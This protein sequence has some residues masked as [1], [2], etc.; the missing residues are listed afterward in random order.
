MRFLEHYQSKPSERWI[1]CHWKTLETNRQSLQAIKSWSCGHYALK[2]LVKKI[3]GRTFFAFLDMFSPHHYDNN[4]HGVGLWLK[5][6]I[7]CIVSWHRVD[8]TKFL[9]LML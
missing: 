5:R 9:F 4:D 7:K 3:Q 8:P 6:Q 1:C 2:Y